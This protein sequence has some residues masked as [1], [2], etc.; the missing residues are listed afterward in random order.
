MIAGL[1]DFF[2]LV[3]FGRVASTSDEAMRLAAAGAPEGTLV[4]AKEQAAGRGRRGRSWVSPPGNLYLS[5]LLRP[6]GPAADAA[7]LGFAAA[8]A[9]AEAVESLAPAAAPLTCKWPNDV[10][11][12]G[13]KLAGILLEL[14]SA[15]AGGLAWL[16]VGVGINIAAHPDG[17]ETPAIALAAAG[18]APAPEALLALWA[19]RM[20]TWLAQWRRDGFA[21]LRAA[22]LARAHGLGAELRVRL[23]R[24]EFSGRFAGLDE[25][26]R[27]LV[28]T[29]AGRRPVAAA[30]VFAA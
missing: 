16:I 29:A 6:A 11:M 24:E 8:L 1:S 20:E 5:L 25:T 12:R 19:A 23:P 18:A 26:G 22:W 14:Q 4:W 28:D 21:P 15:P 27:L 30:E 3:G 13:R 7:Q 10:L 2:R 17:T 9:V